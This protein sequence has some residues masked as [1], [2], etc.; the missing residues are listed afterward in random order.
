MPN[1]DMTEL[2]LWGETPL[3]VFQEPMS[4]NQLINETTSES[5]PNLD[6]QAVK[7]GP[8]FC[9]FTEKTTGFTFQLGSE[10]LSSPYS[11]SNCQVSLT[12][13]RDM[14]FTE[15]NTF[16]CGFDFVIGKGKA[17]DP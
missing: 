3:G 9:V 13:L 1:E 5:N 4:L 17:T 11:D 14:T 12:E 15:K 16:A 7:N 10:N 6:V 2:F 8:Y